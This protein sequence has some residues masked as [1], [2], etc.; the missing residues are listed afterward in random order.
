[1][2]AFLRQIS[3]HIWISHHIL[4]HNMDFYIC[5]EVQV[6]PTPHILHYIYFSVCKSIAIKPTNITESHSL[7]FVCLQT[8]WPQPEYN[9]QEI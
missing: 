7:L 8:M 4:D 9:L 5:F 1:M 3:L 2:L 6:L